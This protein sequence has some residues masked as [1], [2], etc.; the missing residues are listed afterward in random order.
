[1]SPT[2]AQ[3]AQSYNHIEDTMNKLN[4]ISIALKLPIFLFLF[5]VVLTT[6]LVSSSYYEFRAESLRMANE[7]FK[8][9]VHNR[10]DAIHRWLQNM[11]SDIETIAAMPSTSVALKRFSSTWNIFNDVQK[12]FLRE[13]Y[14]PQD[15]SANLGR[16]L[17]DQNLPSSQYHTIHAEIHTAFQRLK[18]AKNYEDVLLLSPKG[19]VVYST[20]KGAEFAVNLTQRANGK[21]GLLDVFRLAWQGSPEEIHF[22]DIAKYAPIGNEPAAFLAKKVVD[23][24]G[25]AVGVLAFRISIQ[26]LDTIMA[27]EVGLGETGDIFLVAEDLTS[28]SDSRFEGRHAILTKITST[29]QI[30]TA[31]E[32]QDI[33]LGN[34]IGQHGQP[35]ISYA[36]G[37]HFHE[38]N[39]AL[40]AE[41]DRSEIL[42]PA[43]TL[44]NILVAIAIGIALILS[45]IGLWF[46]RSITKPLSRL[47][48]AVR[49]VADGDFQTQPR[50]TDRGDEIGEI[51]NTLSEFQR[52]LKA[53]KIKEDDQLVHQAEQKA[54][55][56][57]LS[58]GL[59]KVAKGDFSCSIL[60]PFSNEYD[61]LR[62]DFNSTLKTLNNVITE[63]VGT[64]EK[65][66]LHSME[67]SKSS[68]NLSNRTEN[69]AA[70]LEQTAAALDEL[71]A[72]VKSGA[73]G[74][75][76]V[77]KIVDGARDEAKISESVVDDAVSAMTK[78]EN[79]SNH[80]SQII[81]VID[82][83]A[84]QTNL[85]AL[86]AGVE[87]AR[88]GDAGKG[89]AVVASEV[90]ALAQRSSEAAKEIKTLI[91]GSAQQVVMGVEL[92]GKAG[93]ALTSI[94]ERVSHISTLV[95]EI[96]VG[97]SEQSVGLGEINIGVN[98]LDQVTQQN[99][100]MVEESTAASH[101][102]HNDAEKLSELVSKFKLTDQPTA[103]PNVLPFNKPSAHGVSWDNSPELEAKPIA[104]NEVPISNET[105]AG[106]WKDF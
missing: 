45:L 54:V 49:S 85:L 41:Q 47:S 38:A 60:T 80:I 17:T 28:R 27:N 86:N 31:L 8:A 96:S 91:D 52:V 29:A 81:S 7:R 61:K 59:V 82:D 19:D 89:F 104:I 9:I 76:S 58:I 48:N 57:A 84:F 90:R 15:P 87:A 98:Q 50:D 51:A 36:S 95:S 26:S 66:N 14:T 67:I 20:S 68:D 93:T 64:A 30:V 22:S 18:Q 37:L 21:S 34:T 10:E 79:S 101:M 71:T 13:T 62:I 74:A 53:S 100:A 12:Q 102:L 77:E 11:D 65:I 83:I 78:I 97:V 6:A 23:A 4:S 88:A 24:S 55:V 35:V 32:G 46:T 3:N 99:A 39:W 25:T 70:T 44:R 43:S 33:F 69:Q 1:M 106:I 42:L 94:S 72:S 63:V 103:K 73:E 16:H 5:C 92:V 105:R 75:K 40:V 56:E 2:I